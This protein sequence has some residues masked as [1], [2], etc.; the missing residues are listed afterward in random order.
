MISVQKV[1]FPG[2][3]IGCVLLIWI[4]SMIANPHIVLAENSSLAAVQAAAAAPTAQAAA[5][6][7]KSAS[8]AVKAN[9]AAPT[10][11]Q[12]QNSD[13]PLSQ[14][15]PDSIRKWCGFI[16]H[17]AQQN[18]L[19]PNLVAAV[20]LQESGG[21]PQAY[22]KSGAVGLL[23]V[24]PSDGLASGFM[25][26]NGPCFSSRP[27]TDELFDPEFNISYGTRMLAGL[28]QKYGDIREAL[29]A[30]G[31]INMGYQY[32]DIILGIKDRHQ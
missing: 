30:Y 12:Q 8:N 28:I 20:M 3:A 13:C 11:A 21:N 26:I 2:I 22:S 23:Q 9:E 18:N 6:V 10:N 7:A 19:E 29:R 16:A 17:Y 5:P 27:S 24:M 1:I 25:C 14:S 15:Y 31:P 32:A 4:T